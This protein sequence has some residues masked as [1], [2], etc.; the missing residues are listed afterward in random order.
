[1][2]QPPDNLM[3]LI[4]DRT[5]AIIE[6]KLDSDGATV[7]KKVGKLG[8]DMPGGPYPQA[9]VTLR[10][11]TFDY[12]FSA[13]WVV[14]TVS[15]NIRVIAGPLGQ[16]YKGQ[17]EDRHNE[18]IMAL[19]NAINE[20]PQLELP[21]SNA[22]MGY[23]LVA[24]TGGTRPARMMSNLGIVGFQYGETYFFGSDNVLEVKLQ[25]KGRTI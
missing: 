16:G 13:D 5:V 10:G 12:S 25:V 15:L 11:I 17:N 18:V 2:A 7:F 20:K 14:L 9:A 1:M 19:F 22:A 4:L 6:A 24:G 8:F 23:S 3:D 21:A